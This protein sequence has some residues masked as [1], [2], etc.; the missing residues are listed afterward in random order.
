MS[1]L[2]LLLRHTLQTASSSD[3]G[4]G[5]ARTGRGL[6]FS[7]PLDNLYAFGKLWASYADEPVFSAFHGVQ[8]AARGDQR[9][10]PLFGYMG[11]G[12]FQARVLDNGHIRLRGKEIGVFT[13]L[14]SGRI[15]DH[16]NNPYTG[17]TVEVFNFFNDRVRGELGTTMPVF[18]MGDKEDAPTLMNDGMVT[19]QADGQIPFILPWERY[20]DATLLSWDYTHRYRNPVDPQHW[21]RASTGPIINPSEHFT[22]NTSYSELA[23]RSLPCAKYHCGFTRLSPCWPWM[24]MGSEG[25]DVTLFGRMHS[26]KQGRGFEDI[27]PKLLHWA[28]KHCPGYLEPCTDW[29]DG[30]PLSTWEAYARDAPPEQ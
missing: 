18:N 25:A 15:L 21:P 1:N 23:D 16:W 2:P 8:F 7:S 22:F 10:Q 5:G 20:G 30:A 27:P 12:N 6:D 17:E 19:R 28:E 4:G 24:R 9:L 14:P 3:S 13:D 26:H 11:F 29:D